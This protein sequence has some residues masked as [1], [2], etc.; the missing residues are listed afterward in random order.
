MQEF[1]ERLRKG[2]FCLPVCT[3]CG[4]SAWPPSQFCSRC[5]SKTRLKKIVN[6]GGIVAEFAV[7]HVRDRE[8]VFGVIDLDS[9]VRLVGSIECLQQDVVHEGMKVKMSRCGVRPDG[10]AFYSFVPARKD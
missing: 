5:L 10:T 4:S 7:S 6:A 2:E 8:G 1:I 3:S 9:G